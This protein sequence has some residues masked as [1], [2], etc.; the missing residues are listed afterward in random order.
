MDFNKKM[1]QSKKLVHRL[2]HFAAAHQKPLITGVVIA[3]TVGAA[4]VAGNALHHSTLSR[5]EPSGRKPA[6]SSPPA[7]LPVLQPHTTPSA[8]I[9]WNRISP[10][11]KEPV[12]AYTDA[13]EGVAI[14]VSQ[15]QIPPS[16]ASNTQ[17]HVANLAASYNA[18]TKLSVDTTDFY[19][20][21]SAK[22][23]QSVI[24]TKNNLLIMIKSQSTIT[25]DAWR[26]YIASLK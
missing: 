12:F 2:V 18:T 14:S 7:D 6:T 10:P 9:N 5:N 1:R 11:D 21:A 20:G 24:L 23:P 25:D 15:Q 3:L 8:E 16:F 26:T 13:I 22:G 4:Y 19:I 17:E